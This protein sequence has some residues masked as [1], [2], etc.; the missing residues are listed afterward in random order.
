MSDD[1]TFLTTAENIK[2]YYITTSTL[3]RESLNV[4][5]HTFRAGKSTETALYKLTSS[6]KK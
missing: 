1:I 3:M 2:D 6:I 4:D 5:Q